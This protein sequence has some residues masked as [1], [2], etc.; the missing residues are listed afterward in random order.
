MSYIRGWNSAIEKAIET[1][2]LYISNSNERNNLVQIL[3][4]LK[5]YEN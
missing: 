2:K 3:K 4:D 1:T 5:V